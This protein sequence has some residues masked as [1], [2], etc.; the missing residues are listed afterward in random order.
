MDDEFKV[1]TGTYVRAPASA[2]ARV[3]DK[4][5]R[6]KSTWRAC[7]APNQPVSRMGPL[8]WYSDYYYYALRRDLIIHRQQ[9]ETS[10]IIRRV[11]LIRDL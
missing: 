2:S 8:G 4:I 3:S 10:G 1:R 6:D 7:E 11:N 5:R 9:L